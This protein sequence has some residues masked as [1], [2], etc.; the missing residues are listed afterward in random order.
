[1]RCIMFAKV[2][3]EKGMEKVKDFYDRIINWIGRDITDHANPK[4][5]QR[6]GCYP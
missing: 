3:E 1:M 4:P 2:S 5:C 6:P